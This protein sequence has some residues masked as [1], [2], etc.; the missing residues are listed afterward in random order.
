MRFR[1]KIG[2]DL[3]FWSWGLLNQEKTRARLG[4]SRLRGTAAIDVVLGADSRGRPVGVGVELIAGDHLVITL[5]GR[6]G[7]R[8]HNLRYVGTVRYSLQW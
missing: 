5:L 6:M 4:C 3:G 7:S 1:R 8:G 2:L